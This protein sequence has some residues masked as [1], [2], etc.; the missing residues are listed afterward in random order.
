MQSQS[1]WTSAAIE[2]QRG[3][4]KAA[5]Q[6]LQD[7]R[8]ASS[9]L[10]CALIHINFHALDPQTPPPALTLPPEAPLPLHLL[11]AEATITA[12][13]NAALSARTL[14]AEAS[15]RLVEECVGKV[16][17]QCERWE[18]VDGKGGLADMVDRILDEGGVFLRMGKAV[19]DSVGRFADAAAGLYA[20]RAAVWLERGEMEK[21]WDDLGICKLFRMLWER[22]GASTG[23]R[24]EGEVVEEMGS[25][26]E[27]EVERMLEGCL[28]ARGGDFEGAL[29]VLKGGEGGLSEAYLAAVLMVV[30][31]GMEERAMQ[32]LERCVGRGHRTADSLALLARLKGGAEMW[33]AALAVDVR[34]VSALWLAAKEFG[35]EGR[36]EAQA[37]LLG[38]LLEVL[39]GGTGEERRRVLICE[40]RCTKVERGQVLAARVRAWCGAGE[41][42][43]AK[44][45]VN[46]CLRDGEGGVGVA[47]DA[48]WVE[49]VGGD[50]EEGLRLAEGACE[51]GMRVSG[52][53]AKGEALVKMG[54]L[55]EAEAVL[56]EAC[57]GVVAGE[58]VEAIRGVCFHNL[59]VVQYCMGRGGVDEGFAAAQTAFEKARSDREVAATFARCVVM[60]A[61][62]MNEEG[63]AHWVAKR[64]LE[65][66][67]VRDMAGNVL[68]GGEW[69][70]GAYVMAEVPEWMLKSMD[71]VCVRVTNNATA[72]RRLAKMME[73]VEA[74]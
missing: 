37:G 52:L 11:F 39:E 56:I 54:K 25:D 59:A 64:G 47:A 60:F 31:G 42:E 61:E 65:G 73:E 26:V 4:H 7:V 49:V 2:F 45:G 55:E 30:R 36:Y 28:C 63:A 1:T 38:C 62:G 9:P 29:A 44:D 3:R 69:K 24:I 41:W 35:K 27:G 10:L 74:E 66:V 16:A 71:H 22:V 12:A 34:R 6:A 18:D 8:S 68:S 15:L 46:E 67:A 20:L 19:V 72:R 53:L 50:V 5:Q 43:N 21:A 32:L 14:P 48:A 40:E 57:R 33:R 70:A 17:V 58:G 51:V 23:V 13:Y